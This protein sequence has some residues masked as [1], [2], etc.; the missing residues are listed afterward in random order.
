MA[1]ACARGISSR[2]HAEFILAPHVAAQPDRI[3]DASMFRAASS[4][5]LALPVSLLITTAGLAA[6]GGSSPDGAPIPLSPSSVSSLEQQPIL[7]QARLH[8]ASGADDQRITK[9]LNMLESQSD[10]A[11]SNFRPEGKNFAAIVSERGRRFEVIIDP[12]S[13]RIIPQS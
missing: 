3:G 12:D 1:R 6:A 8:D 10:G 9:A 5:V 7:A 4:V 11:F 2:C 13:G